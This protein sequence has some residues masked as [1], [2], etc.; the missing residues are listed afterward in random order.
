MRFCDSAIGVSDPDIAPAGLL[1]LPREERQLSLTPRST[2]SGVKLAMRSRA[3]RNFQ[4]DL[5]GINAG[6]IGDALR[7]RLEAHLFEEDDQVLVVRFVHAE[8][9]PSLFRAAPGRRA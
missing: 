1:R 2:L 7:Q 3:W 4:V 8:S 5:R 6:G 9:F